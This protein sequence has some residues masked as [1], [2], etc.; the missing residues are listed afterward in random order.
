VRPIFDIAQHSVRGVWRA[1]NNCDESVIY[2]WIISKYARVTSFRHEDRYES[3]P[4][5]KFAAFDA[6]GLRNTK[7]ASGLIR[8]VQGWFRVLFFNRGDNEG[9]LKDDRTG[10]TREFPSVF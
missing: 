2:A 6:N 5:P 9:D 7:A 8:L 10:M 3:L 1:L 4:Y